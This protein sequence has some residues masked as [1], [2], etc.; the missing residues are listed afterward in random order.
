M[1]EEQTGVRR[2]IDAAG[3][4]TALAKL[5]DVT[6]FAINKFERQRY[7]PLERAKDAHQRW[8]EIP[9][10]DMVRQDLRD[11]MDTQTITS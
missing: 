5:W 10:R 4:P 11:A 8:P 2:A 7:F 9:L 3:G 6:Y 1:A